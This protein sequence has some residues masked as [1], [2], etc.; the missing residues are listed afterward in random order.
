MATGS[1]NASRSTLWETPAALLWLVWDVCK[2]YLPQRRAQTHIFSMSITVIL[3]TSLLLFEVLANL[4]EGLESPSVEI[5][6][7]QGQLAPAPHF[8]VV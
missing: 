5:S 1:S 2:G 3:E 7:P 4:S 6:V 8:L